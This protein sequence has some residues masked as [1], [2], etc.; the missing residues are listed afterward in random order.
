M[1]SVL[2]VYPGNLRITAQPIDLNLANRNDMIHHRIGVCITSVLEHDIAKSFELV[3]I[4]YLTVSMCSCET[5][6]TLSTEV[7]VTSGTI[8]STDLHFIVSTGLKVLIHI[9]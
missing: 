5:A 1:N 9:I 7:N 8:S 3:L 6:K 2:I 4:Y